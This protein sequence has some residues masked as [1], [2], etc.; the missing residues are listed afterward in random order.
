MNVKRSNVLLL[1][2]DALRA[3]RMSLHGYKRPTTPHLEALAGE[4]I[5]CDQAISMGA[6]TQISFHSFMTSSRPL[7][8]G[9]FDSGAGGRPATLFRVFHD[10]GYE[11]I[12]LGTIP[13]IN[14]YFGYD[15]IDRECIIF[16]PNVMIGNSVRLIASSLRAWH[17]GEIDVDQVLEKADLEILKM[18]DDV[19]DFCARRRVQEPIDRL[20]FA[21]APV[22]NEDYD[23]DCVLQVVAR[24]RAEYLRDKRGYVEK[25]LV[26]VPQPH[27]WLAH[28]WRYCRKPGKLVGEAFHRL[29]NRLLATVNPKLARLRGYRFKRFV[30]GGDLAD[31]VLHEVRMRRGSARPF[32]LWTHFLDPHLPYAAGRGRQWYRQ[33]PD[34]LAAVGHDRDLDVSVAVMERP[35]TEEEWAT[36][37]AH[38]DA[39]VR[40]IDEQLK[41]VLDGLDRLGLRDDT[42]VV[43]AGDHGEELGEHGDITHHYRLYDHNLRVPMVFHQPGMTGR[44]IRGLTTLLDLAPTLVDLA[45]LDPSPDWEGDVVTSPAVD[46]RLFVMSE[47]FHGGNCLF[48]L[49]PVYLA[50]RT[51]RWKY[52]W[53]EYLDPTDHYSPESHELYDIEADPL[54]QTNLYRPD[55]PAVVEFDP[56]IAGRLA[57][58][59]EI[60]SERI[61]AAIGKVGAEAVRRNRTAAVAVARR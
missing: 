29:G 56:L 30:D 12:A 9:G 60:S 42:L 33:T 27:E 28:D 52:M 51:R 1:T 25:H 61:V 54:E 13:V 8:Y 16:I 47:T 2:V 49:R 36:W 55:H 41:R 17:R 31:R 58:I 11:T 59:P 14:R 21:N 24:H 32:F 26:T 5:V 3:D 53:K 40:Y 48:A 6:F 43:I 4:A 23:F 57:E 50:V 20:H 45:G 39:V 7:S 10:A 44:R 37:S 38:Y 18:F 35:E 34:Y 19:D 22:I 15:S 46:A